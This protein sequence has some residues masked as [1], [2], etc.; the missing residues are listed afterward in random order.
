M[1]N[2]IQMFSGPRGLS[3]EEK[4]LAL[5]LA[6]AMSRWWEKGEIVV[7]ISDAETKALYNKP[8]IK[9]A[10]VVKTLNEEGLSTDVVT[11]SERLASRYELE[12]VGGLSFL[13]SIANETLSA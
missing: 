13:V 1:S 7:L 2:V 3:V 12:E 8:L 5:A 10:A 6:H 9:V 11:V 4:Y